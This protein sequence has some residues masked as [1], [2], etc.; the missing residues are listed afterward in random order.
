MAGW[1]KMT[2]GMEV[3][4]GPGHV[5]LDG[6]PVPPKKRG[7]PLKK[8]ESPQFSVQVIVIVILLEHCTVVIGMFKFKF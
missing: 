3:C 4:L 2:L 7:E 1:I 5:V 6:D 8:G